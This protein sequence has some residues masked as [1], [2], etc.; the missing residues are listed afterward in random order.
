M[1]VLL[2]A[3]TANEW[4]KLSPVCSYNIGCLRQWRDE[5]K[6]RYVKIASKLEVINFNFVFLLCS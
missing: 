5:Y 6:V 4:T 1:Q 3:G 2:N